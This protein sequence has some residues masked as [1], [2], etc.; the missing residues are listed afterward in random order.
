LDYGSAG[1]GSQA[2]LRALR[3][4]QNAHRV[5]REREEAEAAVTLGAAKV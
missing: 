3:A 5:R 1:A 2:E 4:Q